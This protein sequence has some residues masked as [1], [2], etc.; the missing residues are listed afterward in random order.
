[1]ATCLQ[2]GKQQVMING[3]LS[4]VDTNFEAIVKEVRPRGGGA[5]SSTIGVVPWDDDL[6][7]LFRS[8]RTPPPTC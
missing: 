7:L 5:K 2:P 4:K 6:S 1:M 8:Q 3:Q